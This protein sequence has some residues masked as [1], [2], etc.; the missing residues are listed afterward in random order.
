MASDRRHAFWVARRHISASQLSVR[1]RIHH[2]ID[3]ETNYQ[4]YVKG[5]GWAQTLDVRLDGK[6]LERFTIGGDA[7]GTPTPLSFSGTG[8]PGSIDWEQYMLY[9]ATEGL[10]IT[11][12]V[13]AG[14]HS[15][16]ASTFANK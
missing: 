7:P 3:L 2:K 9:K 11:V 1:W 5:L 6:L 15:V 8:E 14:P 13:T 10:E 4:D 16:T 12:P